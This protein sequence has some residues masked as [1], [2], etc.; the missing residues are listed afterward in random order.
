MCFFKASSYQLEVIWWLIFPLSERTFSIP[1]KVVKKLL[2]RLYGV[3]RLLITFPWAEAT[4]G[5]AILMFCWDYHQHFSSLNANHLIM[6]PKFGKH[7]YDINESS[8]FS[9]KCMSGPLL[10]MRT[11][12]TFVTWKETFL[13]CSEVPFCSM[14]LK[15]LEGHCH[16]LR[17]SS[18]AVLA[19]NFTITLGHHFLCVKAAMMTAKWPCS[20]AV[21]FITWSWS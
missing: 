17:C 6:Q 13:S 18:G 10:L 16:L 15:D 11:W 2:Y 14:S 9:W 1:S 19:C 21:V 12:G 7:L 3:W 20:N 8:A 4:S 5:V